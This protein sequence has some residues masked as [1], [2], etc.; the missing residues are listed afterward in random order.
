MTSH[1][2]SFKSS[3]KLAISG[4]FI[5]A[6]TLSGCVSSEAKDYSHLDYYHDGKFHN[7]KKMDEVSFTKFFRGGWAILFDSDPEAEPDVEIPVT[8]MT[9]EGLEYDIESENLVLYR[10]GHSTILMALEGRFWLFDPVFSERVS[11][12]QWIGPKRFHQ[13]PIDIKSLPPLDGVIISHNHFDHLD[14]ASI[15][16][17]ADKTAHFYLP[18]GNAGFLKGWDVPEG[19]IT[20]L[21][22]WSVASNAGTEIISTPAQHFS[23]RS[24]TDRNEA[25]WSSWVVRTEN[26]SVFFNGDSGYFSG[27]KQIGD[28]YGPFDITMME[29]GAYNLLWPDVHMRPKET[30]MAHLDLKGQV[31]LPI[32]NS[33]FSLS[34]HSWKD[35]LT[36]IRM[37]S[38]EMGVELATPVI[39]ERVVINKGQA[40]K[41]KYN[42][43]WWDKILDLANN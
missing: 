13:P 27:F 6:A 34:T 35:P 31:M 41:G 9:K 1:I 36:K 19:K 38:E 21:G 15:R 24:L 39:G 43:S 32:H 5:L 42:N 20:E 25:L 12:Y 28:K 40:L 26:H 11:P 4:G 17:L 37:Y 10:L 30:V 2:K 23:G 18:L 3:A 29:N 8:M 16:E 14:E 33:T 7:E 22:W